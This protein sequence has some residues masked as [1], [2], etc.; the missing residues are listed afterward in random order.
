MYLEIWLTLTVLFQLTNGSYQTALMRGATRASYV[1]SRMICN[2]AI[3]VVF[4]EGFWLVNMLIG[5]DTT[6]W[7]IIGLTWCVA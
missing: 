1:V 2:L 3:W 5:L 4:F 6:G 7:Q